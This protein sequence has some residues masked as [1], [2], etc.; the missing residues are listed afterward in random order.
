[1]QITQIGPDGLRLSPQTTASQLIRE[2][3]LREFANGLIVSALEQTTF[4]GTLAEALHDT[5]GQAYALLTA[6]LVLDAE[7]KTIF[8]DKRR[9]FPLPAF[10][11]YRANLP[12]TQFPLHGLRLPPLNPNGHYLFEAIT[13]VS[14]WALRLDLHPHLK[15]MGHVRL[16]TGWSTQLPLRLQIVEHRLDRQVLTHEMIDTAIYLVN[17]SLPQPLSLPERQFL[18]S[19]LTDLLG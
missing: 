17:E 1:M 13:G 7:V 3:L 11:S 4:S 8:E 10:L 14:W 12:L 18:M 15:V 5:S 16:A 19:A 2:S 9:V 6:L